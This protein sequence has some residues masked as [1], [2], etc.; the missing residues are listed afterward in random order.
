MR[1]LRPV[2]IGAHPSLYSKME[3]LRKMYQSKG[4]N[5][6]Q[7]QLTDLISKR[8]RLPN[9]IDLIGGCNVKFKKKR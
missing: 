9:K 7:M 1:R 3:E 2:T 8:I 6:S 5:L 4:I